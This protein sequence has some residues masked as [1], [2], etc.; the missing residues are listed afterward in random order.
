MK[1][2]VS[3]D[4]Q[5]ASYVTSEGNVVDVM[6]ARLASFADGPCDQCAFA[7]D[8]AGNDRPCA[9]SP[10]D[11]MCCRSKRKDNRSIVWVRKPVKE[12]GKNDVK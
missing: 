1:F 4:Q 12:G 6:A 7:W 10:H 8:Y 2:T 5:L 11:A 9:Y 3:K